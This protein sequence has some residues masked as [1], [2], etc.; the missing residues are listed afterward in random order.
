M[1]R[2]MQMKRWSQVRPSPAMLVASVALFVALSGTAIAVGVDSG[3]VENDTLRSADLRNG[4]AVRGVD[5]SRNSLTGKDV[6]ES[7]L[8]GATPTAFAH[9]LP[10]GTV[11]AE[12]SEGISS[13]NVVV[14]GTDQAGDVVYCLINL[15]F[16]FRGAQV[17]PDVIDANWYWAPQIEL[18]NSDGNCNIDADA[19]V[20]LGVPQLSESGLAAFYI[21]FYD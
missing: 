12:N 1:R 8:D 7:S 17:T 4:K 10:A 21:L 5:V 19:S 15:D 16:P 14:E 20:E 11:D 9:V 18:G 3:A 6:K 13:A 2:L